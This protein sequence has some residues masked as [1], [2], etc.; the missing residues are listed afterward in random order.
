LLL[1][2]LRYEAFEMPPDEPLKDDQVAGI[3]AWIKA[4]AP[5]PQ[6]TVLKPVSPI[7]DEDRERWC[8]QPISDPVVPNVEDTNWPRNEIDRFIH[9]RLAQDGIL[10]ATEGERVTLARRVHFAVT[11]LPPGES[12]LRFVTGDESYEQFVDRL[13]GE[14]SYGENQARSWLDL[15][16]YA[17]SDGYRADHPRPEAKQYRDY[18]I[19][20]F[21]ADKPYDRF[22][23]EQLAGDE[24]DP[25]NRD[26]LTATMF[27]R[28]WIY[29]HNQRDVELQWQ[30]ILDDITET[31]ADV[32]LAQGVRCARCHDHKFDP[33]LQHDYFRLRAFFAAFQPREDMPVGSAEERAEF[34]AQESEWLQ[35]T[36]T[37]RHELHDIETPVLLDHATKEGFDKFVV[38]IK[39]MMKSPK[40][41]RTPYEQQIASLAVRQLEPH[42]E[43]LPEQLDK[44]TEARGQH[45]RKELAEFDT[46][47]PKPLQTLKF[48]ASDVGPVAPVTFIP[49]DPEKAAIAPGFLSILDDAPA[50]IIPP[51]D[52]LQSTGRRSALARW[53]TDPANPLTARVI[54]NRIWQQHFR[55]G[56][57]L[58]SSDF[59]H[60]GTP[61]SHPQLLDWLASRFIE[62]G[63][64]LKKLHRRILRSATYR[65]T[66]Q[67]MPTEQLSTL[68]PE[69]R[70]LW[71][72]NSRRLSGE[73]ITDTM[74]SS[75]GELDA[76]KRAVY[77][78]V[79]RNKRD[80]LLALFDFPD[81]IRSTGERHRTTTSPQALLLMNNP[82]AQERA[83]KMASRFAD[84][85]NSDLVRYV[86]Q[87]LFFRDPSAAEAN[88][89]VEFLDSYASVTAP[90]EQLEL[91]TLTP[92]NHRA[93]DLNPK[94]KP[95]IQVPWSAELPN[96]DFT[97]EAMVLLRSVYPDASVRT[98]AAH[99]N[100]KTADVGWALGVTSAKSTFQPRNLILQLVGSGAA[101]KQHYEVVV[102]NLRV[103]LN[104]P[105]YAAVSVRLSDSLKSGI[106]FVLK[107]LSTQESTAQ[108]ASVEH[109]VISNIRPKKALEVGGR[110][111]AHRWD[112]LISSVRLHGKALLLA[113]VPPATTDSV[114]VNLPFNLA[115]QPGKDISG[116]GHH[117]QIEPDANRQG[118]RSVQARVSLLHALMNSNEL[119][120]VD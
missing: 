45:L 115:D 88:A 37:I 81:R 9:A 91:P 65:Q 106:T 16:R 21:N 67:R 31:T 102:S 94:D 76:P 2:A 30:E 5:W 60:L 96:G 38:E 59:G 116:N 10:P 13:L 47:K 26:A 63:W 95:S 25:G 55:H 72:M 110:S 62:D 39:S 17:D 52:S 28:L 8:Y 48:V 77:K 117:A 24:L 4:G 3:A 97:I 35:A 20:S 36:A 6:G 68:D 51:P 113:D 104:K 53:I 7:T 44:A 86:Y 42:P 50:S 12:A 120:Y 41:D 27:L 80:P 32:L 58:T 118:S 101:G 54:V 99:W 40:A 19:R 61:P 78:P 34:L 107:D 111:G 56:L 114:I 70:L 23:S 108:T 87:E 11:G 83:A 90:L 103:E 109:T 85:G 33:S 66:S 105:Y 100:G 14:P 93:I 22:V 64:S 69:N 57:V 46:I 18:V 43:K 74:M 98:I 119:I 71:R 1:Q 82:W 84:E 29:E 49:D 15:V 89:S 75:S 112:G 73:E 79:M 92:T